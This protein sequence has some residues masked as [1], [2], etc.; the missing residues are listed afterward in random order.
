MQIFGRLLW[1]IFVLW[2]A[3]KEMPQLREWGLSALHLRTQSS[4][5]LESLVF[6]ERL[7]RGYEHAWRGLGWVHLLG[8][9]GM[10][11]SGVCVGFDGAVRTS[12]FVAMTLRIRGVGLALSHY[13]NQRIWIWSALGLWMWALADWNP[14]TGRAYGLLLLRQW[15]YTTGRRWPGLAPLGW[16]LLTECL[17]RG[18]SHQ[19]GMAHYALALAG[20][21]WGREQARSEWGKELGMSVGSWLAIIPLQLWESQP[22]AL[23]TPLLSLVSV[24]LIARVCMPLIALAVVSHSEWL[25]SRLHAVLEWLLDFGLWASVLLPQLVV[26][27]GSRMCLIWGGAIAAVASYFWVWYPE[28]SNFKRI[29]WIGLMAS[30]GL[31]VASP[32]PV[33]LV[34]WKVGQGDAAFVRLPGHEHGTLMDVGPPVDHGWIWVERLSRFGEVGVGRVLLSHLD[35]DHVGSLSGLAMVASIPELILAAGVQRDPRLEKR[36]HGSIADIPQAGWPLQWNI[37]W[38][39]EGRRAVLE[40]GLTVASASGGRGGNQVM[41]GLNAEWEVNHQRYRFLNLGDAEGRQESQLIET[42]TTSSRQPFDAQWIKVSHHGSKTSSAAEVVEALARVSRRTTAWVSVGAR[43]G[44]HHPNLEVVSRWMRV[45]SVLQ[46]TD[47][48]GDLWVAAASH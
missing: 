24:P 8:L 10:H 4:G 42:L 29:V 41:L 23:L 30:V 11:L 45:G 1:I 18:W 2:T 34:Q 27:P 44:Y 40:P 46:R 25:V 7:P 26:L 43:N 19:W 33:T 21:A 35:Q 6:G 17:M 47:Q 48:D 15:T 36:L 20:G 37:R 31:V 16:V 22:I 13:F 28:V 3:W 38:I 39:P 14:S 12:A 9:S 5:V 32:T